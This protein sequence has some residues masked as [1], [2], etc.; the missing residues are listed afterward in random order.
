ML[1]AMI[2]PDL[3]QRYTLQHEFISVRCESRLPVLPMQ[4]KTLENNHFRRQL[5]SQQ[6]EITTNL[7][8]RCSVML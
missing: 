3:Q 1:V 6:K 7:N 2:C 4:V 5:W 8:I